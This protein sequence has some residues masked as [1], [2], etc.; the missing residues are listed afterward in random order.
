MSAKS[1]PLNQLASALTKL[2]PRGRPPVRPTWN[3]NIHSDE[4][5]LLR[6]ALPVQSDEEAEDIIRFLTEL[7]QLGKAASMDGEL[8]LGVKSVDGVITGIA[9][10]VIQQHDRPNP[11]LILG[12][13][14]L[15][16][17]NR[18]REFLHEPLSQPL[19]ELLQIVPPLRR[20][21]SK[22]RKAAA[23]LED[24][25]PYR[26]CFDWILDLPW[27]SI[28]VTKGLLT[29]T[30]WSL[31]FRVTL[32]PVPADLIAELR[33]EPK[34]PFIP[35]ERQQKILDILNGKSKK[36]DQLAE[37]LKVVPTTLSGRDLKELKEAGRVRHCKRVGYYRPDAPPP[38]LTV[39]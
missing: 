7:M 39:T 4:F 12:E 27:A 5:S 6:P 15:G 31:T 16:V 23:A 38:D 18:W 24:A 34:P 14:L 21:V 28:T 20:I 29:K 26:F 13:Q 8:R 17:E 11:Q 2:T 35:T 36:L 30:G 33:A 32:A 19:K 10:K 3:Y 9:F 25:D 37:L 1:S 22:L